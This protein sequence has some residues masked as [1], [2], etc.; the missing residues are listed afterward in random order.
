MPQEQTVDD[1]ER[2]WSIVLEHHSGR[3]HE[4]EAQ[5]RRGEIA[6]LIGRSDVRVWSRQTGSLIVTGTYAGPGDRGAL[7]EMERIRRI[8]EGNRQP[9]ATAHLVP[10]PV[11]TVTSTGDQRFNLLNARSIDSDARYTVQ[12]GVFDGRDRRRRAEE[13]VQRLRLENEPAFFFHGHTKSMVTVGLF[14]A[15][16][17]DGQTG[18]E[19]PQ[20]LAVLMRHPHNLLNGE[21]I[22]TPGG[23]T[24][25]SRPVE[26]PKR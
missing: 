18:R 25:P 14:G 19:G 16:A 17:F 26:I 15:E 11:Q 10:P 12:V 13:A 9:F 3:G 6:G 7:A 20:I 8:R 22:E 1:V 2:A 5:R 23:G 21:P 24:Q 4:A